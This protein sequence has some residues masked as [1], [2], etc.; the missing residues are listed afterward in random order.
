LVSKVEIGDAGT[1]FP[2]LS[3]F[4]NHKRKKAKKYEHDFRRILSAMWEKLFPK[5]IFR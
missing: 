2:A 5:K 1:L 3:F 4:R